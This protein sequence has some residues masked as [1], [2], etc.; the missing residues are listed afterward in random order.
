[1]YAHTHTHT[2]THIYIYIYN[3]HIYFVG[4]T[5]RGSEEEEKQKEGRREEMRRIKHFWPKNDA[6]RTAWKINISI[7]I[8][9]GAYNCVQ[10]DCPND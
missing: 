10:P 8:S 4:D 7:S 3:I 1:M 6:F 2:H 9:S 5:G